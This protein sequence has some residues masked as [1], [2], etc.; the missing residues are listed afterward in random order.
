MA[1]AGAKRHCAACGAEHFP[2]T[3]PVAIMMVVRGEMCL[4]GRGPHFPAG[5]LSCLAGFV[6]QGE[7][8]ED[9]VR[10]ETREESG[11]IVGDVRYIASQPW[12]MPH[13]LMIGCIAQAHSE[14]IAHDATELELCG[15]FS[16]GAVR[17]MLDGTH[18]DGFS[19]PLKGAI[20]GTLMQLWVEGAI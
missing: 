10:R 14:T 6:E 3:D 9:A 8:I 17:Q 13:S 1:A 4:L 19:A 15:W 16:R 2:R 7:T 5:M 18:P 20:A 12:P 11:I